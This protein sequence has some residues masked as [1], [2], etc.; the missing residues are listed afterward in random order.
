MWNGATAA[1]IHAV[2]WSD[3]RRPWALVPAMLVLVLALVLG[4]CGTSDAGDAGRFCG[5]ID[6]HRGALTNPTIE[7]ADDIEP[8]LD[9]YRSIGELAPIAIQA[10]WEQLVVNYE[11]ASTMVPGDPDSEQLVIATALQSE[12]SAAA[13]ENWLRENCALEIGPL[14][15]LVAQGG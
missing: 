10:E 2:M 15:T 3:A 7:Y 9:L 1:M 11:T 4:G 13:V 8:F 14:S 6:A 5:E 12:Q